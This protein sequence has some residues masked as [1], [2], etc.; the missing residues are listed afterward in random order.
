M[1]QRQ[2][3]TD[4][5]LRALVAA[6]RRPARGRGVSRRDFLAGVLGTAGAAAVLAACGG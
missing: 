4:P 5:R 2:P 6:G 3:P 1:R